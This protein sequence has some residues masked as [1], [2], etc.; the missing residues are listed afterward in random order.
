[1]KAVAEAQELY[2]RGSHA[3]DELLVDASERVVAGLAQSEV[4]LIRNKDEWIA[5]IL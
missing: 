4:G 3:G 1:M 5:C 2:P